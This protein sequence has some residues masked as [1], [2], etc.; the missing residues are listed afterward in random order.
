MPLA[1]SVLL[2]VFLVP[3]EKKTNAEKKVLAELK[4]SEF[5]KASAEHENRW[6][7]AVD[8][9]N[10]LYYC[11]RDDCVFLPGSNTCAPVTEMEKYIFQP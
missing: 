9:W 5:Q 6:H 10:K 1:I 4:R 8:R 7:L 2:F 11:G 3:R